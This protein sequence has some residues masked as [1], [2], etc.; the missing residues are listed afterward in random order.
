MSDHCASSAGKWELDVQNYHIP[1]IVFNTKYVLP[2]K[3]DKLCSQIDLFPTIFGL[4]HWDY[5]SNLFGLDI[6][7]MQPEDERAFIGNYRKLGLLKGE[8]LMVLNEQ[9]QSSFYQWNKEDNSLNEIPVDQS[10]LNETI[11]F[12]QVADYLYKNNG[13]KIQ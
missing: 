7:K 12:Y 2:Q 11:S 5:T 13:L 4:L 10:F 8:K 6:L 9:N 1:A 3:I